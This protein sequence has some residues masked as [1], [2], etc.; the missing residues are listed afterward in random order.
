MASALLNLGRQAF[1]Q[2][3]KRF[4]SSASSNGYKCA[5]IGAAGGIGQP[6][7]LLMKVSLSARCG[8][9]SDRGN[10]CATLIL[11]CLLLGLLHPETIAYRFSAWRCTCL[12]KRA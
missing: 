7:S 1:Q 4:V 3:G 8:S 6:L 10:Q 5:V 12:C 9:R 11:N 2:V